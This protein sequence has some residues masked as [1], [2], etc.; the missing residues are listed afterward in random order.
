MCACTL[1]ADKVV[2]RLL[3]VCDIVATSREIMEFRSASGQLVYGQ[4]PSS[5]ER[6]DTTRI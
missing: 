1:H 2:T 4:L 3:L 5:H 6:S